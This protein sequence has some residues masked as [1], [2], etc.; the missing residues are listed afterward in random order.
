MLREEKADAKEN[1]N[2]KVDLVVQDVTQG[3]M[4]TCAE[5]GIESALI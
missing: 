2:V 5:N 4:L 3:K 1:A